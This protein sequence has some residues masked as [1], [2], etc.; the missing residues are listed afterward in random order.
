MTNEKAKKMSLELAGKLAEL[1]NK[2]GIKVTGSWIVMPEHLIILAF[3]APTSD[4][5][6]KLSVEP[7]IMRFIS[8]NMS[9]IKMAMTLEE[10]MKM[11]K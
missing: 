6:Q 1:T 4:T 2:H 5:F 8:S 7:E 9:E 10:S 11:L 3:E